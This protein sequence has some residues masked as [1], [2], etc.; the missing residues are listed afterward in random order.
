MWSGLRSP[1]IWYVIRIYVFPTD[2][3]WSGY[4]LPTHG[5]W[6]G[7]CPPYRVACGQGYVHPTDGMW[8]WLQVFPPVHG[9]S[10]GPGLSQS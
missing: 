10:V 4:V 1:H 5:M 9:I 3:M 8:P 7:L 2:G 6:L